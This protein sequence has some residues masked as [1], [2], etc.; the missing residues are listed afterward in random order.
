MKNIYLIG[1]A[2]G[3]YRTQNL[4]KFLLD[5]KYNI[6]HN[7]FEVNIFS[8]E[9]GIF[10]FFR[11]FLKRLHIFLNFFVKSYHIAISDIVILTA[12]NNDLQWELNFA[13]FLKKYIITDFYLSSYDTFILDRKDF[14]VNDNKAKKYLNNDINNI[15]AAD[16]SIF[17]NSSEASYYLKILSIPFNPTKH[18]IVP[19]C[20]EESFKCKIKYFDNPLESVFNICWWGTY[21][22]L[23]G[24][25][26][27]ILSAKSLKCNYKLN[28][29]IYLFGNNDLKSLPYKNI[30]LENE[31]CDYITIINDYTFQNGK[32][33]KFLEENCDL[34][35]GNFGNSDKA[36]SVLVNKLIDGVAMKAPVLTGESLAPHEFFTDRELFYSLNT[37]ESVADSIHLISQSSRDIILERINRSY[38]IYQ[39]NF[40]INAY[41]SKLKN[42]ISNI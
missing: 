37:P 4:I 16:I 19:L 24:L 21:I 1:R 17:L 31:L 11:S 15:L 8:K 25:E 14:D 38:S 28:F 20:V 36:R 22:P 33:N 26:N 23:H 9:K 30:I 3:W 13:K 12:M 39:S 10:R 40:S 27:I 7:S 2:K 42:L 32:L 41:K 18:F 34:V 5:E 6:Y 29:H 35:L